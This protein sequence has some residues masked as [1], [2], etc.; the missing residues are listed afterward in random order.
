VV[1]TGV[2]IGDYEDMSF[3]KTKKLEDLLE[4]LLL[5]T[6]MPRFRLTSLEPVEVTARMLELYKDDRLC[7]HFHMSIQSANS[8]V[9]EKMKRQYS[10]KEVIESLNNIQMHLPKAFVGMDVIT[11]F[12]TE[13]ET[14]FEDTY[15]TL[16]ELPWTRIHVFP[17]SERPGTFAARFKENVYPHVRAER[18]KQLRELSLHRLQSE[19]L[20]QQ[21]TN[22]K[23]L[24]L[25]SSAKGAQGLSR[26]YWPVQIQ[27][28][29]FVQRHA[30]QE[31]EIKVG[32]YLLPAQKT[33]GYFL[34]EH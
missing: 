22:K 5:Q 34:H 14:D 8:S 4:T 1:L 6:K 32:T 26:C 19:A 13:T 3:G 17:Y 21:H 12:P 10:Q 31:V 27:D 24:I 16:A 15:K 11:G 7:A 9:L 20:K 2:H 25:K 28:S 23:V 18:A 30:G 33:E 29:E